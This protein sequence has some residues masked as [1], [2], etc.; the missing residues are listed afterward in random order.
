MGLAGRL[1]A[2]WSA[3]SASDSPRQPG[4]G[5]D[6]WYGAAHLGSPSGS[7]VTPDTALHS[8][9][10]YAC[11]KILAE[12]LASLPLHVYRREVR[13]GRAKA[14]DHPLY[15]V[16]HDRPNAWQTSYEWR[17]LMQGWVSLRGESYAEI[18][19]GRRGFVD[20]LRPLRPDR[21]HFHRQLDDGRLAWFY[22]GGS[23]RRVVLQDEIFRV[24]GLSSDGFCGLSV[25]GA[26]R[27]S[28]GLALD[29]EEHGGRFFKN[30]ARPGGVLQHPGRIGDQAMKNLRDSWSALHGGVGNSHRVAILE[31]GMKWESV[32]MTNEDAQFLQTR[33]FQL[34]DIARWFRIPPHMLGDLE[35]ATHSNIEHSQIEFVTHTLRP[36]L[37]NWEQSIKR[38]LIIEDEVSVEFSVDGLLRGDSAS[39]VAVYHN[40]IQDGWLNPN[41][42][43][44]KENMPAY[45]GGDEYRRQMNTEPVNGSFEPPADVAGPDARLSKMVMAAAGRVVAKECRAVLSAFKSRRD[46]FDDWAEEFYGAHAS[47]LADVMQASRP[48]ALAWCDVQRQAA[49]DACT[50]EEIPELVASWRETRAACLASAVL[51]ND[52]G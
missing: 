1:L 27:N 19:P 7:H 5:S 23:Q 24:S 40:G 16:L 48:V 13:G 3:I 46:D 50:N 33:K 11:I 15:S 21:M 41:E 43:R 37:V 12:T 32:S 22:D 25:V 9:A 8:S 14:S 39:R 26:A 29:L 20:Q 38:D 52:H 2:A 36:W 30:G 6:F 51:E 28:I 17:S 18:V 34:G 10:V 44:E 49:C 35:R 4:P 42:V 47:W 45:E 31:E